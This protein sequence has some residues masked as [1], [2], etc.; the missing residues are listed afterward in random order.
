MD[1][2]I[3]KVLCIILI[4]LFN[5][6]NLNAQITNEDYKS[7]VEVQNNIVDLSQDFKQISQ[8]MT[9]VNIQYL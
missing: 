2:P 7:F 1:I 3:K 5:A 6:L 8:N 4:I 9:S